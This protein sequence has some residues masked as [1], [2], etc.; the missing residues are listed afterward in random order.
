M[1]NT[2]TELIFPLD[3]ILNDQENKRTWGWE[4]DGAWGIVGLPRTAD[5]EKAR[6][7]EYATENTADFS[8]AVSVSFDED[9]G[10]LSL[11]VT[12]LDEAVEDESDEERWRC[13]GGS[14]AL[15]TGSDALPERGAELFFFGT[16]EHLAV[17]SFVYQGTVFYAALS[18]YED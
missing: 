12:H 7:G 5:G 9:A 4:L 1:T 16:A 13:L 17:K 10:D 11:T 18:G 15:W 14:L 2:T 8:S 6:D 3:D